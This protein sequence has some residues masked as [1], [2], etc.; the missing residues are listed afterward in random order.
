MAINRLKKKYKGSR[1]RKE[2]QI[3]KAEMKVRIKLERR[4]KAFEEVAVK[5]EKLEMEKADDISNALRNEEE[6]DDIAELLELENSIHA[7][8]N[9]VRR[10]NRERRAPA[11]RHLDDSDSDDE[12]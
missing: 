7:D 8:T 5:L 3:L 6:M 12:S 9:A 4:S 2:K 10:S 1:K 11:N